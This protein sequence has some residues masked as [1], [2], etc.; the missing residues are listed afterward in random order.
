LRDK[1]ERSLEPQIEIDADGKQ[2]IVPADCG[3]SGTP[4][5]DWCRAFARYVSGYQT[6]LVEEREKVKLQLMAR[7]HGGTGIT[8]E[9]YER[10]IRELAA[11]ALRDLTVEELAKEFLRR[12]MSLPATTD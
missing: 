7:T 8:D 10:E 12:G 5:R 6:L 2:S 1:L 11:E 3:P 9:E 4:S